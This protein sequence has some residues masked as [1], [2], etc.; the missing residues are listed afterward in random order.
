MGE[1][2]RVTKPMTVEEFLV[3]DSGDDLVYELID[4]FPQLKDPPNPDL[5]GQA[6]PT[7]DHNLIVKNLAVALDRIV[8]GQRRP[9]RVLPGSGQRI[10]RRRNRMRIPDLMVKCGSSPR[11]ATE[12]LLVAEVLSPSNTAIDLAERDMDYR[13]LPGLREILLI[14]QDRPAVTIAR[15]VGDLWRTER[16]EG[17]DAV[18]SLETV[19][20]ELPLAELYRDVLQ[21]DEAAGG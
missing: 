15:R 2:A 8:L 16:V 5:L 17:L 9:C 20:A 12:P 6:A 3:W 10:E 7:D 13:S 14:E 1:A 19:T 18:L 4:G 21:P 11:D